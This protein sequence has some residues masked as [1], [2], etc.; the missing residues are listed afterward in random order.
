[1]ERIRFVNF[2]WMPFNQIF[3]SITSLQPQDHMT[4]RYAKVRCQQNRASIGDQERSCKSERERKRERERERRRRRRDGD[5]GHCWQS[6]EARG[7]SD[8]R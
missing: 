2:G 4:Y 7:R 8:E 6:R 5:D 3:L 1:M